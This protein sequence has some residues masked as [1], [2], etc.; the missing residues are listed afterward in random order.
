MV[1]VF[2]L[3][4]QLFLVAIVLFGFKVFAADFVIV[5]TNLLTANTEQIEQAEV[6]MVSLQGDNIISKH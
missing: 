4:A 5:D 3:V 6:S 2:K 1:N